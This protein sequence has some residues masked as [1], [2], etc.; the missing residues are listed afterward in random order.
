MGFLDE[1]LKVAKDRYDSRNDQ[2]CE[3]CS[4]FKSG[5]VIS[6]CELYGKNVGSKVR[7]CDSF[8]NRF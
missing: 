6:T 8:M 1:F 4:Y 3:N 2:V 5:I 7:A